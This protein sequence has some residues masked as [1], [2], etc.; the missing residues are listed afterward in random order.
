MSKGGSIA[1]DPF[2]LD[3]QEGITNRLHRVIERGAA[4]LNV[5]YVFDQLAPESDRNLRLTFDFG[6]RARAPDCKP[7]SPFQPQRK[8]L[9]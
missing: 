5:D 9:T 1:L 8:H 4:T 6:F 3:G 7:H 2:L